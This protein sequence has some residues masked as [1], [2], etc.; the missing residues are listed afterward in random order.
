MKRPATVIMASSMVLALSGTLVWWAV[1]HHSPGSLRLRGGLLATA[2]DPYLD[3]PRKLFQQCSWHL[4]NG[5]RTWGKTY[6]AKMNR[7]YLSVEVRHTN[8]YISADEA[9][10]N[11]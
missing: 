6:G 3:G 11:E 1:F 9:R 7:L 8:P 4:G 10:E 2:S 5:T